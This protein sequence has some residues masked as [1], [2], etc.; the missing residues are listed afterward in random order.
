MKTKDNKHSLTETGYNPKI[1]LSSGTFCKKNYYD[2]SASKNTLAEY[3]K[4]RTIIKTD[5]LKRIL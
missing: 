4:N 2:S 5:T 1:Q 3:M